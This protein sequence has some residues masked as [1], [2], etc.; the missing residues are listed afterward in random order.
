MLKII[1][2]IR[3]APWIDRD[4]IIS[5]LKILLVGEI[6]A[7]LYFTLE[8]N[9]VIL[10]GIEHGASIDFLSFYTAGH[11]ANTGA[12]ELIYQPAQLYAAEQ[13]ISADEGVTYFGFF[14]PPV[15]L[16]IC[17][18]LARLPYVGAYLA[19][20]TTT[21]SLYLLS[22]RSILRR[23]A[24]LLPALAFPPAFV[25]LG[26]GQN[27]FLTA[28]LFGG[29]TALLDRCPAIAGVLFGALCYKP[30]FGL[31]LPVALIAGRH[32]RAFFSATLTV[33]AL[34]GLSLALY[35]LAPWRGFLSISSVAQSVF[36]QGNVEFEKLISPFAAVRFWGGSV[37][38]ALCVQ[39]ATS[40]T[41]AICVAVVWRRRSSLASRAAVLCSAT[42][43]ALPVILDYDLLLAA[44]PMTWILREALRTG[45]LP[46]E[47]IGLFAIFAL[48]FLAWPISRTGHLQLGL[49]I[50]LILFA[51]ALARVRREAS[52][53]AA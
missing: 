26:S 6:L 29:A 49:P 34:I 32:W 51:L 38:A 22:I 46:W 50:S 3:S 52:Q 24:L 13:K 23:P 9:G 18:F 43:I 47:K 39:A 53:A 37:T 27:S 35:G 14:Y 2:N 8:I 17:S 48:A 7:F 42:L 36:A 40:V 15:F 19:W 10:N 41:A 16:L 12:A 28:A 25:A 20:M 30:H 5:Y 31:L 33:T 45:F 4:R 44:I 11:M 21:G 1:E